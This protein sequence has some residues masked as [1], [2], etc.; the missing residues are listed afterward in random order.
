LRSHFNSSP[1]LRLLAG[2]HDTDAAAAAAAQTFAERLSL[3]L[4]WTDAISLSA[5]LGGGQA[6]A[7]APTS[8]VTLDREARQLRQA[9]ARAIAAGAPAE[10]GGT[11]RSRYTA[12]QRAMDARIGPLR[13]RVRAALAARSAA[14][15][16]LA[17]LDAAL[18]QILGPRE[19][20]LLSTVPGL[21]ERHFQRSP[22][23]DAATAVGVEPLVQ[24]VLL[25]ELDHRLQ[26]VEGLLEALGAAPM[27]P[28][29]ALLPVSPNF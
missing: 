3:W 20:Q 8:G 7:A 23:S 6:A 15:G 16:R 2:L 12:Q 25:A 11:L 21:L 22:P 1:L 14:L 29:A 24:R 19:R 5:A 4:D 26:P 18:E 17:A 13:G 27:A 28:M 10:D 9:L